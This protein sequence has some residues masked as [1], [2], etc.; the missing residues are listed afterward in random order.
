MFV[1]FASIGGIVAMW[2]TVSLQTG[3]SKQAIQYQ[4]ISTN[5]D[6]FLMPMIYTKIINFISTFLWFSWFPLNTSTEQPEKF[7]DVDTNGYLLIFGA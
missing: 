6:S 5:S 7:I 4:G 2:E 3:S 1:P